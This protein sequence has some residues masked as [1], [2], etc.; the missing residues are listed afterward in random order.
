[1]TKTKTHT[2]SWNSFRYFEKPDFINC[3]QISVEIFFWGFN[4][5]KKDN[6]NSVNM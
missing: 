6:N 4:D 3:I 2:E 1:M 5:W